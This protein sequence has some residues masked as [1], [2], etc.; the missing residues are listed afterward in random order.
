MENNLG[1]IRIGLAAV[2]PS[3]L[4]VPGLTNVTSIAGREQTLP[5]YKE[6]TQSSSLFKCRPFPGITVNLPLLTVLTRAYVPTQP[7]SWGLGRYQGHL[8]RI[9]CRLSMERDRPVFW[10]K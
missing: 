8:S 7:S 9:V 1:E 2:D 4:G 10:G 3:F 5:S 6:V